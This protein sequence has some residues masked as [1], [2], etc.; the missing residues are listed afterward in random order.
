M[1]IILSNPVI[2]DFLSQYAEDRHTD[3]L[4]GI[5]LLGIHNI[6]AFSIDFNS[7]L[8]RLES[9]KSSK[10]VQ[11]SI[12]SLKKQL[13]HL[14]ES[15]SSIKSED[16]PRFLITDLKPEKRSVSFQKLLETNRVPNK[17]SRSSQKVLVH[18]K[19]EPRHVKTPSVVNPEVLTGSTPLESSEILQIADQFLNGRFV[20]EYCKIEPTSKSKANVPKLGITPKREKTQTGVNNTR[21]RPTSSGFSSNSHSGRYNSFSVINAVKSTRGDRISSYF[22]F[23]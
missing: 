9:K 17:P 19:P 13:S 22:K 10:N 7:I 8:T 20:N 3:C 16:T 11:N 21:Y 2:S 5:I 1:N 4:I 18:D 6:K 12:K 23:W 15:N 14:Q